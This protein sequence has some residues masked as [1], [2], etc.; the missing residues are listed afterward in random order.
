MAPFQ[1]G[2]VP[3]MGSTIV[4]PSRRRTAKYQTM[5]PSEMMS[6][7]QSIRSFNITTRMPSLPAERLLELPL[8]LSLKKP[9]TTSQNGH[10]S[11]LLTWLQ[12]KHLI[13]QNDTFLTDGKAEIV[14][15]DQQADGKQSYCVITTRFNK[16]FMYRMSCCRALLVLAPQNPVRWLAVRLMTNQMFDSFIILTIFVNMIILATNKSYPLADYIFTTIYTGEFLI[17]T[18]ARGFVFHPYSY[19]RNAWNWLDFI[20]IILA[21]MTI[22]FPFLPGLSALRAFRALKMIAILPA[23]KTIVGAIFKSAGLL[24]NVMLLMIFALIIISLFGLQIF[25]GVLRQKCVILPDPATS[26]LSAA[27]WSNYVQNKSNWLI[28]DDIEIMVCGNGT[29]TSHCPANYT[30]LPDIGENP[31]H[32]A[33][34]FDNFGWAMMTSFQ[35]ITIDYWENCYNMVLRAS[36]QY[37]IGF[38]MVVIML[39][40]YYVVNLVL[41]VVASSYERELRHHQQLLDEEKKERAEAER[42][43]RQ[44]V[45]AIMSVNKEAHMHMSTRQ[46]GDLSADS[47][48]SQGLDHLGAGSTLQLTRRPRERLV[49][50]LNSLRCCSEFVAFRQRLRTLVTSSFFETFI[51]ILIITN[52]IMMAIDYHNAPY[53]SALDVGNTVLTTIFIAEAVLKLTA[54]FPVVYFRLG[55]NIFDFCVVITSVVEWILDSMSNTNINISIIRTFRIL[56]VFKLAKKWKTLNLLIR[57]MK[58]AI[59][60]MRN[61]TVIFALVIYI[62][63]VIGMQLIGRD[64]Y[65]NRNKFSS[66]Q[67]PRWNFLDFYSSFLM[68]FRVLCGEWIEPLYECLVCSNIYYCVPLF[69]LTYVVGG[70][71]VLNLFLALLLASFGGD[72]LKARSSGEQT[73]KSASVKHFLTGFKPR[74]TF[75]ISTKPSRFRRRKM[76]AASR[77]GEHAR[78]DM[79]VGTYLNLH[80]SSVASVQATQDYIYIAPAK[81]LAHLARTPTSDDVSPEV[82]NSWQRLNDLLHSSTTAGGTAS[83]K[84]NS[85]ILDPAKLEGGSVRSSAHS[86][87]SKSWS[88]DDSEDE[89]DA[90]HQQAEGPEQRVQVPPCFSASCICFC[91]RQRRRDS[92]VER[93]VGSDDGEGR[94]RH[95][96]EPSGGEASTGRQGGDGGR[97][98]SGPGCCGGCVGAFNAVRRMVFRLCQTTGF[99]GIVLFMVILSSFT[100]TLDDK[101]NSSNAQLMQ[102]LR[103]MDL[104]YMAFFSMEMFLKMIGL[105]LHKYFTSFWTLLD[106]FLVLVSWLNQLAS[107]VPALKSL[108]SLRT[109]RAL[110]PLRA[111]SRWKGMRLVVNAL[112]TSIPSISNVMLMCLLFWMVFG[113]AGVQ[114]F[115]GKFFRCIDVEG[116]RLPATEVANRTVCESLANEG[117]LWV[118][119]IINYDN[120]LSAYLALL[121]VATLEGWIEQMADASDSTGVDQQPSYN[122]NIYSQMFFIIFVIIGS[123]FILNLFIGVVI[124]NFNSVH[125]RSHKEGALM[126]LLTEDQQKFYKTMR[127]LYRSKPSKSIPQPQNRVLRFFYV[128]V[129][130]RLFEYISTAVISLNMVLLASEHYNQSESFTNI[131]KIINLVFTVLFMLEAALKILG[132]RIHYFRQPWD[133]FDFFVVCISLTEI[134]LE[135]MASRLN[136]SPAI[137]RVFRVVRLVRLLRLIRS[138]GGIRKLIYTLVIS[139]PALINIGLLLLLIM[140]MYGILG[141]SIFRD[142]PYRGSVTSMVNFETFANSMTLL[143]RLNT[144]GGWNDVMGSVLGTETQNA[145]LVI[146]Y[147]TTFVIFSNIIIINMY[148][149]IILENFNE[150]Q[151]QEETGVTDDDID[152]FYRVWGKFDP[153]A[154]QFLACE[155]LPNFFDALKRPFRIPKPN[156]VKIA[157]LQLAIVE[158]NKVHC[159]DVLRTMTRVIFGR[160]VKTEHLR[161]LS[162]QAQEKVMRRF[163]LRRIMHVVSTTLALRRE[164]KAAHVI[165]RAFRHWRG[166]QAQGQEPRGCRASL[167]SRRGGGCRAGAKGAGADPTE[168][169]G[170][171]GVEFSEV[172]SCCKVMNGWKVKSFAARRSTVRNAT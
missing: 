157:A 31:N 97:E 32:G 19:L 89:S 15:N 124:D 27:E 127:R 132:N 95:G 75:H 66:G 88:E 39:G 113:I 140:F 108:R 105:G 16:P 29:G 14:H 107:A 10:K 79:D 120:I 52:T 149:A 139:L 94:G 21:Y 50:R 93:A 73:A 114:L 53:S 3:S 123:F 92:D 20:V 171:G 158:G 134:V 76:E 13:T 59:G 12:E 121:Q 141:V 48:I 169:G 100:L 51:T 90:E 57:V 152:M 106:C 165:Q 84:N 64:Y 118:N 133:I 136:F 131:T 86:Q 60:E 4:R 23:L 58:S 8:R 45:E 47:S 112:V 56:R 54:L 26:S 55:W 104:F 109:L 172:V 18:L 35:I 46:P 125:K 30:C 153:L 129:H 33:T 154:T 99:N 155:Q 147:F 81:P 71:L 70:F 166:H 143:F 9:L 137:L 162:R 69:I 160:V 5:E 34:S 22:A 37:F 85:V 116:N 83:L 167:R 126:A 68:V 67:V 130:R 138:V 42:K 142:L 145:I 135:T 43:Q 25:R 17:K 146:A 62:F 91:H 2:N 80:R 151:E 41:A 7:R 144:A 156:T 72:N 163:P 128:L 65:T 111:I 82:R 161:Q 103:Y 61:L 36:G 98:G 115:G 159:L 170:G 28:T 102:V 164:E 38:F 96:E 148:V 11:D 150:A 168:G 122:A 74:R 78:L 101:Y 119:A 63:A 24:L 87:E 49:A 77:R 44:V 40:G 110:R 1:K 117:Y 6:V